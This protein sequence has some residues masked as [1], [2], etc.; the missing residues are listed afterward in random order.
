[1]YRAKNIQVEICKV[2]IYLFL[3]NINGDIPRFY[4]GFDY[5]IIPV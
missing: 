2:V 4:L 3:L 5:I 1:M